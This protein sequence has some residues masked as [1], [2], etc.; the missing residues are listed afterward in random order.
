[1][2]SWLLCRVACCSPV[3][4]N[5]RFQG[6]WYISAISDNC[7]SAIVVVFG[8]G[9]I[10]NVDSSTSVGGDVFGESDD[11]SLDWLDVFGGVIRSG[12]VVV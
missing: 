6:A 10:A 9:T 3:V 1:M 5:I 12:N 2:G 4:P 8:T 11:N 7:G